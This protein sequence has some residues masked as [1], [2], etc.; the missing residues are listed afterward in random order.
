[1]PQ[2]V[3]FGVPDDKRT[4]LFQAALARLHLAPAVV[5]AYRD[6]VE[7]K[8]HLRDCVPSGVV[9]RLESSG[10]DLDTQRLFWELGATDKT[11][12]PD[13]RGS[14]VNPLRIYRGMQRT[15]AMLATQLAA[16]PPYRWMNPPADVLLMFDKRAC[17][18]HLQAHSI[19]QAPRLFA[20][21]P[22]TF[23]EV[24]TCMQQ[25][26][27]PAIF[28]KLAHGSSAIGAVAYRW[29]PR[30]H[31]HQAFTTVRESGQQLYNSRQIR[32]ITDEATIAALYG[33]L[34]A[35]DDLHIEAWLPKAAMQGQVFD[36]R[37]LL[38]GGKVQH[39]V[40]RLSRTPFTNLHLLNQR[41][42]VD[43]IRARMRPARWEALLATCERVAQA[44]PQSL[45][46]G[47]DVLIRA[48]WRDHA[49]LEVNAFGDLLND[50][51][52]A[53]KDTYTCEIEALL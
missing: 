34:S 20:E 38:I 28:I 45:Y 44:F 42:E 53:G 27:L 47:L 18:E 22:R 31:Q 6:L 3:L 49:V 15:F 8:V 14:L 29:Q 5:V 37:V 9:L 17:Y 23:A 51:L 33:R 13:T 48:D 46:M 11:P 24:Q 39:I 52:Y 25:Q 19:A 2:F 50:V 43:A 1:M 32:T 21:A 30:L 26:R 36:L 40:A 35:L 16:C 7:A 41:G 10:K 4:A 12:Y